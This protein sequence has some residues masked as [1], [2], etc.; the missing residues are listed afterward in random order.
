[1]SHGT[2][3]ADEALIGIKPDDGCMGQP[4]RIG[5]FAPPARVDSSVTEPQPLRF[6]VGAFHSWEGVDAALRDLSSGGMPASRFSC[7]GLRRVLS[8]ATPAMGASKPLP[9]REL[10]FPGNAEPIGCTAGPL[11]ERLALRLEAGAPTLQAA[12][13]RW[14]IARHAAHLEERVENGKI[15]LWVQ[16]FDNDDERR[17]YQ[18]LL[19]RSSSSVGVHDLIGE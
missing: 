8:R 17:A 5:D 16:L 18:S 6:A 13:G 15:T 12:L 11:A 10:P 14:L 9:L 4:G 7:L 1:M 3:E 2:P 19:T